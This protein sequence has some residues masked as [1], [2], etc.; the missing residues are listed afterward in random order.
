MGATKKE[1]EHFAR[2]KSNRE[3]EVNRHEGRLGFV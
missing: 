2:P 1:A 3:V